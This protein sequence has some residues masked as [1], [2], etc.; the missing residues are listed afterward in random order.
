[1]RD[2]VIVRRGAYHD[3]VALMLVSRVAAA[4]HGVR[5]ASV[6]MA[7][8]LNLELFA[9][10]GFDLGDAGELTVNDLVIAV[11]AEDDQAGERVMAVVE[12][13]L[14]ADGSP[15]PEADRHAAPVSLLAAT[16]LRPELSVALVSVPGRHVAYEA[17]AALEAGLHVF[18]FS[19]GVGL[20]EEAVLKR[21][22]GER[23]LLFMGPDCG[24]AI[25]DGV[26]F[27]FA[28]AV[29]R[30]PVGIVG[31]SGTGIQEVCCLL[32][33]GGVGISHAIGVGG[34]DL[35]ERIGGAMLRRGLELLAADPA[36][37]VIVAI[38]K[39]P[40]PGVA[41]AVLEDAAAVGKP[42]VVA[43]LGLDGTPAP[44]AGVTCAA[45]LE[46]AAARAAELAGRTLPA[47]DD[48]AARPVARGAIR[49]LYSG[50]TLCAEAMT[51]V[52]AV[53]GRVM[54]NI[55]LRAE[56]RLA[57]LDDGDSH[58]FFDFGA[59]EL[60]VGRPHPMIDPT[61]R[62][63][64]LELEARDPAVAVI[65]LDLVLGYGAHPDPA[66]EFA[67]AIARACAEREE[68]TV[69]VSLCG[70]AG[71]PQGLERQ[72]ARLLDAGAVVTR[73]A[74]RAARLALPAAAA[75]GATAAADA[76]A[77]AAAEAPD[78]RV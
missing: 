11:R 14:S 10:R 61:L 45:S 24:T 47:P 51:I 22:A 36:T 58:A 6:A 20:D 50:G 30:G 39:R 48:G 55:P 44:A 54:S 2:L 77:E 33:L 56:W 13:E 23:G 78:V 34:R 63:Q 9:A 57:G 59:D 62:L 49:G 29:R 21:R 31:A 17:A 52:S 74:A 68:L 53:V 27:G 65:L 8:P 26:A 76:A 18:C 46:A 5:D 41:S 37:E 67:P 12:R 40:D 73:G 35:D 7:T 64:R 15:A 70:T 3:S 4:E 69:I 66:A 28:N 71:D 16:R 75:A 1:M 19:N 38:A 43:F 60:T 25:L 72:R 32:D 42:V